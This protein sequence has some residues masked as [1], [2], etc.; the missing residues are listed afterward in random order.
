[1][2]SMVGHFSHSTA[3]LIPNSYRML[4]QLGRE[5]QKQEPVDE[6]YKWYGQDNLDIY[7]IDVPNISLV[8]V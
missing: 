7:S 2:K 8:F 1:M 5:E 3:P 4:A 6:I